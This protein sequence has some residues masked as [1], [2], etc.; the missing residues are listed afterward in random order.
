MPA[1]KKP[2]AKKAAAKKPAAKKAAA[3]KPNR[4]RFEAEGLIHSQAKLNKD[5]SA[6]L[7]S[8]TPDEVNAVVSARNKL[9]G[10]FPD[11]VLTPGAGIGP[12]LGVSAGAGI[13]PGGRISPGAGIGPGKR[14]SSS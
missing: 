14:S 5:Q 12:G 7:E 2:A 9:K 13:G 4:K 6:A 1:S 10:S 8:L 3:K 11:A